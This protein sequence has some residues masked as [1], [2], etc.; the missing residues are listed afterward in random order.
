MM[1]ALLAMPASAAPWRRFAA[2]LRLE[3]VVLLA[4]LVAAAV[5]AN[6]EPPAV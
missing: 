5:L 4:A 3:A 2:V 6:G 1:P